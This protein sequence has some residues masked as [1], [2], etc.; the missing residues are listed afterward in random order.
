MFFCFE[1]LNIGYQ[2]QSGFVKDDF[3]TRSIIVIYF[4][5]PSFRIFGIH[6][7]KVDK[8]VMTFTDTVTSEADSV[9][10]CTYVNCVCFD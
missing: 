2:L 5:Y 3:I 8:E 7:I 4:L 9:D 6:S 10:M 1:K